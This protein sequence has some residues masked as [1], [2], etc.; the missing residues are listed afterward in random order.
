[1]SQ[2][3]VIYIGVVVLAGLLVAVLRFATPADTSPRYDPNAIS[4]TLRRTVE[5]YASPRS[6]PVSYYHGGSAGFVGAVYKE[7]FGIELSASE[8]DL[9][10]H[11]NPVAPVA[12]MPGDLLFFRRGS[13]YDVCFYIGGVETGTY[14]HGKGVHIVRLDDPNWSKRFVAARRVIP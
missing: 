8:T 11:G 2:R 9:I 12:L 7:L 1:M 4:F 6:R 10:T 3:K 13:R 14:T 5:G